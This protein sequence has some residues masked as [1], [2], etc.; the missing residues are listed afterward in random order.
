[1]KCPNGVICVDR[2]NLFFIIVLAIVIFYGVNKQMFFNI[3]TK[4]LN[5]QSVNTKLL[6]ELKNSNIQLQKEQNEIKE[7]QHKEILEMKKSYTE[8]LKKASSAFQKTAIDTRQKANGMPINMPTRGD[9][10]D[11]KQVGILS[12]NSISNATSKPGD[13][14]DSVILPLYGKQCYRR[15]QNWFYYTMSNNFNSMKIPITINGYDCTDD[16]GCKEL[17]DGDTVTIPSY[18]GVFT[19]KIYKNEKLRYIPHVY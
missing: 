11:Y 3:Y 7:N 10:E 14:A 19:C 12:K 9:T 18:N 17:N 6:N 13:N 5:E 8:E 16:R 2:L 15:S 4:N 1:M